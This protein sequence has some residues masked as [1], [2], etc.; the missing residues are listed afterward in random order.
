MTPRQHT[1][2]RSSLRTTVNP[3]LTDAL[4]DRL[5]DMW[6][7]VTHAGG[8][9]GFVGRVTHDE[10]ATGVA[11]FWDRVID[12]VVDLVIAEDDAQVVGFGFLVPAEDPAVTGHR[13]EVQKLMRDPQAAGRGVGATVLAALED[14]AVQ[15]DVSLVTLTVRGGTGREAYYARHGYRQ[16]AS[17]PDWVRIEGRPTDLLV[18]AKSVGTGPPDAVPPAERTA[19]KEETPT[20]PRPDDL[21]LEVKRLDTDLPLPAYA[22]P[23]DAGLDLFAREDKVLPPGTRCLMPTGLAVAIPDGWVG[24]VH[25]RSGLAVRQ[26]LSIVNSP[27]TIDAGYRGELMVPLI[28]LDPSVTIRLARGERIA[29]LLLQRVGH[30]QLVEVDELPDGVRGGDGFGST[31]R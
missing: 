8:A 3:R 28:N 27:G 12:G 5:V 31:G 4:V 7:A 15:R 24:L 22:R 1:P 13:A 20:V 14:R 17:L 21:R 19:P 26:G 23:G 11:G 6:V 10:V 30:A 25:P 29:Q 18:M 2:T 16:V 9:V